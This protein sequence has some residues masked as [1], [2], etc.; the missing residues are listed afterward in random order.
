MNL[1]LFKIIFTVKTYSFSNTILFIMN[2]P[3]RLIGDWWHA[4]KI[5]VEDSTI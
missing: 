3:N 4:N 1:G 5:G 2:V